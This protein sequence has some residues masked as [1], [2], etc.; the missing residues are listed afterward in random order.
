M[1]VETQLGVKNETTW[2]TAVTV[3]RFFP[4]IS[5]SMAPTVDRIESEARRAGQ[6]VQR[7]DLSLGVYKGSA[8]S[9]EIPVLSKG[10]GWWLRQM[11]GTVSTG[12]VSDSSYT[13]TGTMSTLLDKSFTMQINRPFHDAGTNQAFTYEGC[14]LTSWELTAA[15]DDEVKLS[16]EVDAENESTATA[17]ATASY[18]TGM[19]M[20][21]WAHAASTVTIAGTAVPITEFSLSV[22]NA[23]KTD[24]YYIQGSGLKRQQVAAGYR[25][26]EW[27]MA[28][29]FASLTQYERM[30]AAT[31]AGQYAQIVVTLKAPTL[32]GTTTYPTLVIT[33]PKARFDAVEI[34]AGGMDPATQSLSGVARFDGT[35]SP[36]TIAY[37]SADSTA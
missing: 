7:D 24:R 9:V 26:V 28:C 25:E 5:E 2:G 10:F 30:I 34:D 20:F 17:L 3:D 12:T 31:N 37:T 15:V 35:N 36:V 4:L 33:I 11:L 29:D 1:A 13:H 32:I 23:L 8:G 18:A 22:D 14:K 27:S 21:S 6:L 19:E 16:A